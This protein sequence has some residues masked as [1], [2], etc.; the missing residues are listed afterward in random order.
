MIKIKNLTKRY[1]ITSKKKW[2]LRKP[3]YLTALNNVNFDIK[4][5][6]IFGVLGPNGAGKTTLL[7][8][9]A[10]LLIPEKG[11]VKIN[12]YDIYRNRNEIRNSVNFLMS[13]GWVIFDYKLSISFNLK[14]WGMMHGLSSENI[15]KKIDK[16]LNLV[17]LREKKNEFIEN[18]SSGMRQKVNLARCLLVER[19]I[20]LLDEPTIGIDA[21]SANFIREFIKNKL[22]KHGRTLVLATHNLWE[23]E[24]LC[25]RFAILHK[26]NLLFSGR[27]SELKKKYKKMKRPSLNKIFMQLIKEREM[28]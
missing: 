15:D 5:G 9:I 28:L 2:L 21:I 20:Y 4:S 1:K 26:G 12:S 25:D 8:I 6:E 22:K 7:K 3:D 24:E 27:F 16:V 13:S 14:F 18:L 17:G 10:G 19:S 23:A 11:R